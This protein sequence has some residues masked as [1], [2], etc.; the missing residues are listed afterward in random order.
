MKTQLHAFRAMAAVGGAA[1]VLGACAY[2]PPR[3]E[4][5]EGARSRLTQLQVD[6]QFAARAPVAM[7]AAEKAVSAAEGRSRN[8]EESRHLVALANRKVD[9]AAAM[10][11]TE[12]LE[13][14]L[15]ARGAQRDAARLDSR[16]REA[17]LARADARS[18]QTDAAMARN[19]ADVAR[20]DADIA[21][22]DADRARDEAADLQ[23]QITELN[24]RTTDR[25]LVVALGDVLFESGKAA[26]R[27]GASNNLGKLAA[28]L[29]RYP[30]RTVIIEGHTDDVGSDALNQ[31]LS[32]RRANSVKAFLV[33]QGVHAARLTTAGLGEGSP[34][35]D[36]GS[37]AGRQQNRRVEV[38]IANSAVTASR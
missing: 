29:V 34:I 26:L 36:N 37:D 18:A 9:I 2:S 32:Q 22:G 17:D 10:T 28:F 19:D 30:D 5:A 15:K 20:S 24:A 1:L 38:I 4:S 16:T 31:D 33:G 14:Q 27:S 6:P 13:E 23:R 3:E 8:R 12:L 11:Q 7:Q 25:G 21:R 35:A